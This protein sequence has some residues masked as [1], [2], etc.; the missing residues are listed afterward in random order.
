M[1]GG[2]INTHHFTQRHTSAIGH[3]Q[4]YGQARTVTRVGNKS[5]AFGVLEKWLVVR[6]VKSFYPGVRVKL[7]ALRQMIEILPVGAGKTVFRNTDGGRSRSRRIRR[8][9]RVS[10]ACS[11]EQENHTQ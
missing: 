2:A 4:S 10:L 8:S 9:Y 6:G 5:K 11:H 1:A 7:A 3:G